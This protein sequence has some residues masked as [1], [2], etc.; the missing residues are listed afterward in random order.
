MIWNSTNYF[1]QDFVTETG[2]SEKEYGDR[3]T[4][5]VYAVILGVT[6]IIGESDTKKDAQSLIDKLVADAE[7]SKKATS[8]AMASQIKKVEDEGAKTSE[9]K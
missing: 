8:D 1:N 6:H 5:Q 7:A 3:T 9:G 4:Y 2:I